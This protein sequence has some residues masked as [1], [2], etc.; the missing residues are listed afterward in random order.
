MTGGTEPGEEKVISSELVFEG[1]SV[2]IRN[3]A[4]EMPSGR[5]SSRVIIEHPG[6]VAV[7]PVLDDGSLVMIRQFRLAAGGVIWEVPAGHIEP[8][9]DPEHCARR[10]LEEETGYRPGKVEHLFEALLSPGSSTE[11]MQFYLA[12][13]LERRQQRTEEDEMITVEIL[14]ARRVLEMIESNE[15]R[16]AKT[17]AAVSYLRANGRL[18]E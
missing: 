4:V 14:E 2:A 12:T 1:R 11:L 7:V 3:V 6:S 13:A 5:R 16:D 15:I 17:I 18:S 9:E 8:G 10:E